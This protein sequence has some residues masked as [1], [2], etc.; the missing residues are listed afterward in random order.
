MFVS[1]TPRFYAHRASLAVKAFTRGLTDS[2][3][4]TVIARHFIHVYVSLQFRAVKGF[5]L[6]D[7]HVAQQ[8]AQWSRVS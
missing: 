6:V 8:M 5:S 7:E 2:F 1:S 3:H 4:S